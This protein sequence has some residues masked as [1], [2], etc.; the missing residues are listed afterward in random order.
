MCW[1][2]D[3]AY[4][5]DALMLWCTDVADAADA[6]ILLMHRCWWCRLC[7][8]W[9]DATDALMLLMRWCWWCA[10]AV[11]AVD[12]VMLLMRWCCWSNDTAVVDKMQ[13]GVRAHLKGIALSSEFRTVVQ[14]LVFCS[15]M[16]LYFFVMFLSSFVVLCFCIFRCASISRLYPC[17]WVSE[18]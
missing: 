16:F 3:A 13:I 1:C 17:E 15:I 7:C 4:A 6:L 18:S 11:D 10:D 5:A 14:R 8:W 12:A 2:A 9:A